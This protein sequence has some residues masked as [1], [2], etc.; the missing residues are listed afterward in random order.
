[1]GT[2]DPKTPAFCQFFSFGFG[3]AVAD[4]FAGDMPHR[5]SQAGEEFAASSE[6]RAISV[7]SDPWPKIRIERFKEVV[8]SIQSESNRALS[9]PRP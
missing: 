2:I 5:K 1:M 6:F 7:S 9:T 8:F 3:E 4:A